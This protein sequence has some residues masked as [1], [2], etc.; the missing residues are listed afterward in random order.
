[1]LENNFL[2]DDE[3][4][5]QDAMAQ[6]TG[7]KWEDF[8]LEVSADDEHIVEIR[9]VP[10]GK[11]NKGK[12]VPYVRHLN[13]AKVTLDGKSYVWHSP[14]TSLTPEE[15]S[16]ILDTFLS[17]RDK[18]GMDSLNMEQYRSI[19]QQK[20]C[21]YFL[22]QVISDNLGKYE[23]GGIYRFA[24]ARQQKKFWLAALIEDAQNPKNKRTKAFNPFSA[25]SYPLS[26][27][28]T[29][30][31][32]GRDWTSCA[33]AKDG[34]KMGYLVPKEVVEA[35][36]G[37]FVSYDDTDFMLLDFSEEWMGK[38]VVGY[39]SSSVQSLED[40]GHGLNPTETRE[41]LIAFV[42]KTTASM[43]DGSY[44]SS[45]E[46]DT[47]EVDDANVDEFLTDEVSSDGLPF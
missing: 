45:D 38:A 14:K 47:E 18:F 42:T 32:N 17:V 36:K 4:N 29:K 16:L 31:E 12:K 8:T 44:F 26:L 35:N 21:D 22:A 40:E 6:E 7:A 5:V 37:K 41:D 19:F 3:D 13:R 11:T 9:L 28:P 33:F 34:G 2:M 43:I 24:V 39:F 46:S 23:V 1:M 25:M 27:Q 30:T 10:T 20:A 15:K